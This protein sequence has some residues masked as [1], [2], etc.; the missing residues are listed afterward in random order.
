MASKKEEKNRKSLETLKSRIDKQKLGQVLD[1]IFEGYYSPK[2][3]PSE[4]EDTALTKE[5]SFKVP[6][7]IP[8]TQQLGT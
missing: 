6:F 7:F 1:E 3:F 8:L 5:Q 4:S 2:P